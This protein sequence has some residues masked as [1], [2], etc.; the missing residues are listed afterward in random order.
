ME[1]R[2]SLGKEKNKIEAEVGTCLEKR[3]HLRSIAIFCSPVCSATLCCLQEVYYCCRTF[4][5]MTLRIS[6]AGKTVL[7]WHLNISN[8]ACVYPVSHEVW[9]MC[10]G[11]KETSQEQEV[12]Q[13]FQ[14]FM[15]LGQF[16]FN[17]RE[18]G[19]FSQFPSSSL[20][21]Q[22]VSGHRRCKCMKVFACQWRFPKAYKPQSAILFCS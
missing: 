13:L 22:S 20:I 19:G 8:V 4:W 11:V 1:H 9:A 15:C 12:E 7:W 16:V 21:Y 14:H 17:E 3:G 6:G 2:F 5:N 18:S 10:M